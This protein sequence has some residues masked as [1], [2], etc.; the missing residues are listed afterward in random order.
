MEILE[1]RDPDV[2]ARVPELPL[3]ARVVRI[4]GHVVEAQR[5]ETEPKEQRGAEN[6]RYGSGRTQGDTS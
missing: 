4:P 2:P 5:G 3:P 1:Q 6:E